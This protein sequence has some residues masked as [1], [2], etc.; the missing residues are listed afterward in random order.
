MLYLDP[1][2]MVSV[3]QGLADS[4]EQGGA[5]ACAG[6]FTAFFGYTV[7]DAATFGALSREDQAIEDEE[8]GRISIEQRNEIFQRSIAQA[9]VAG[10]VN[11]ATAGLGG[12]AAGSTAKGLVALGAR[13]SIANVGAGAVV[14][15]GVGVLARGAKDIGAGELSSVGEYATEGAY[16][17]L[18]GAGLATIGEIGGAIARR[19]VTAESSSGKRTYVTKA[20][21]GPTDPGL[22]T[23]GVR[24]QAGTR[25][26][27]REQYRA[28]ERE[29]RVAR[30]AAER[31]L[32]PGDAAAPGASIADDFIGPRI[33][34]RT[35]ARTLDE[36]TSE[37]YGRYQRYADEAYETVT[38]QIASGRRPLSGTIAAE[39][40]IGSRVDAISRGRL[41][42]WLRSEG[43]SEG[44]GGFAQVN[45]WLRDPSGSGAIRIPDARVPGHIFDLTI[46]TKTSA[47]P[48]VADFFRFSA[49]SRVTIVRP[50]QVGGSYSIPR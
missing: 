9:A 24:P 21:E 39:T 38:S 36:F 11:V 47:T 6:A 15:G 14:G 25:N 43:I 34:A 20:T 1:T 2:G 22:A 30:R 29:A 26:L 50:R 28:F 10:A 27:T 19:R 32:Q 41:R 33:G 13:Q 31:A 42:A 37:F 45:R 4:C 17:A 48:Q 23:R 16:G 35:Q 8:A 46:G 7:L 44:P 5:A 18:F 12:A 40:E 49:G 3:R